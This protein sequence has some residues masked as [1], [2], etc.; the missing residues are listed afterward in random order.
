MSEKRAKKPLIVG[1]TGSIGMGKSATAQMF[2]QHSIPVYDADKE[3][4][5][6]YDKGGA[7]VDAVEAA[8]PGVAENGKIVREKLAARIAG[9]DQAFQR[10]EKIVHP[11]VRA[12]RS[13][14]IADAEA[15]GADIVVFD[16]PL[17][18]ETGSENEVDVIVVASAPEH[19]QQERVMNRPGMS[20]EKFEAIAARQ[21]PDVDKRAWADFV[22]ATGQG[23]AHAETQVAQIVEAL[24]RRLKENA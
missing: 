3:V 14:F 16:I 17:L 7:A 19:I 2:A 9:N 10:L 4:H 22:V 11:L 12:A 1:I 8:F 24:R 20:V 6:L 5:A 15:R 21:L 13:R 18:F 23:F